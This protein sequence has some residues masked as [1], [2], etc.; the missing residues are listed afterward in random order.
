[1]TAIPRTR[2]PVDED[3]AARLG[4]AVYVFAYYEWTVVSILNFLCPGFANTHTKG[5]DFIISGTL[6]VRFQ[7]VINEPTTSFTKVAKHELQACCDEFDLQV[8]KRNTLIHAHPAI[9]QDGSLLL[10]YQAATTRPI[11]DMQWPRTE[12]EAVIGE[13]DAVA[14]NA[15]Q[16]LDRLR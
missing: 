2:V 4:K 12:I 10:V 8:K 6:R 14:C 5:K 11:S 1:M 3:H 7:K 9:A 15:A 16:L 13:F